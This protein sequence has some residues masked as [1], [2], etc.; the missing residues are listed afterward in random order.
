MLLVFI[1]PRSHTTSAQRKD[2]KD[3]PQTQ[4][5]APPLVRT[6]SRHESR[7]LGYGGTVTILGAPTGS[8]TIEAWPKSEVDITAEIELRAGTEEELSQL[9]AVNSF[10]LDEEVN[11]LRLI[12][13]G[14]HDKAFMKRAARGFPKKLLGL[15][16]KIDYRIRVPAFA[17]LEI[18]AGR[19]AINLSGVEGEIS[20]MA[21]ESDARLVLTGGYVKATIER[22]SLNVRLA[23]RSW[24]GSG[25]DIRIATGDLNVEFPAGMSIDINAEVLRSGR[26]ENSYAEL[27]P[28][29]RT[30]ATPRSLRARIGAGGPLLTFTVAD[31]TLRFTRAKESE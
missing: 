30:T 16:W 4:A 18:N 20:L 27:A 17:D 26:I 31:G 5:A 15:P 19:G 11:H 21:V 6:T 25:A 10:I 29:E 1:A 9:A 13:T 22:G 23:S 24:R 7:R 14:T 12:T 28:R 8:I 3:A 2:K